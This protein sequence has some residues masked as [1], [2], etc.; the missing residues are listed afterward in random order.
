MQH[1]L[2]LDR[3]S[4]CGKLTKACGVHGTSIL[5]ILFIQ[6]T[7]M[8]HI[9]VGSLHKVIFCIII[10]DVQY[11]C[12]CVRACVHTHMHTSM[13]AHIHTHT[14]T[15]IHTRTH[16]RTHT[17]IH[18]HTH[19]HIHTHNLTSSDPRSTKQPPGSAK[20]SCTRFEQR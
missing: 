9:I 14:H 6:S 18:I 16:T 5:T 8:Y 10:I 12:A 19:T 2:E 13:Q 4:L 17:H 15:Y 11:V 3:S 7:S 1:Y 20:A